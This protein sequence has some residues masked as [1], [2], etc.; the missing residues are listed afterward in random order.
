M[1]LVLKDIVN[2]CPDIEVSSIPQFMFENEYYI[3]CKMF[4]PTCSI[5]AEL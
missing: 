1:I 3:Y 5:Y 2:Y 4:V